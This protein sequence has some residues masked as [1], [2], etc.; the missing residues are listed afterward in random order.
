MHCGIVLVTRLECHTSIP[1]GGMPGGSQLPQHMLYQHK[2]ILL[3]YPGYTP[4]CWRRAARETRGQEALPEI[5]K[6][7]QA[8]K[9]AKNRSDDDQ[10]NTVTP[11]FVFFILFLILSKIF[12][13]T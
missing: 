12:G 1:L 6:T 13:D 7:F 5:E 8:N 4:A 10:S 3:G 11:F 9:T 2:Y